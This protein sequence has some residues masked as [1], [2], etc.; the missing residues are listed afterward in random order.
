MASLP[1]VKVVTAMVMLAAL[2][3]GAPVRNR[4]CVNR[5]SSGRTAIVLQ[6]RE[7][8]RPAGAAPAASAMS[9]RRSAGD[10]RTRDADRDHA[11]LLGALIDDIGV[12][13][14]A[15]PDLTHLV[16]VNRSAQ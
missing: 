6:E 3:V 9:K 13:G 2:R 10:L 11:G 12:A 8:V 4:T 15:C 7:L 1:S 14:R 16:A 5:L